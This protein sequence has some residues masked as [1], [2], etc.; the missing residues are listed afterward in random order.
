MFLVFFLLQ[1]DGLKGS[2]LDLEEIYYKYLEMSHDKKISHSLGQG[3]EQ[4]KTELLKECAGHIVGGLLG[5]EPDEKSKAKKTKKSKLGSGS[6]A[7]ST[8]HNLW[9]S[10]PEATEEKA[11]EMG[12]SV[13]QS[14]GGYDREKRPK[15]KKKKK[16]KPI[17]DSLGDTKQDNL[18]DKQGA[19]TTKVD[20][21]ECSSDFQANNPN[22]AL[23]EKSVKSKSMKKKQRGSVRGNSKDVDVADVNEKDSEK[24]EFKTLD[25]DAG[26]KMKK[27]SK[28]RKRLASEEND[29]QQ[30][31]EKVAEELKHRKVE[32]LVKS[33]R[34]EQQ[35][36][37]NASLGSDRSADKELDNGNL[38]KNGEKSAFQKAKKQR[39]GSVEVMF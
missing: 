18:D 35:A 33:E 34:G 37:I 17:C 30:A 25:E 10:Q 6:L 28:K 7:N 22:V 39:N 29:V 38:E 4:L 11:E 12:P 23:E 31:D 13:G 8:E 9:K 1:K 26:N 20:D 32:G 16:D 2:T 5:E 27:G 3:N 15:D 24:N 19:V 14:V 36:K 21:V